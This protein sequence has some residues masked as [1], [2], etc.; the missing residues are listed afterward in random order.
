MFRV[1]FVGWVLF[2]GL[3]R[4]HSHPSVSWRPW[5]MLIYVLTSTWQHK[6]NQSVQVVPAS[7]CVTCT[8]ALLCFVGV[9][10][11][12]GE[13]PGDKSHHS[14]SGRAAQP[15]PERQQS[16]QPAHPN[17]QWAETCN[18]HPASFS[19]TTGR[20]QFFF[21]PTDIQCLCLL[22]S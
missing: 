14:D 5:Y 13:P 11:P 2:L 1:F 17:K 10:R 8:S 12:R 20:K 15:V 21:L 18:H 6:K 16:F 4:E 9:G 19:F 7:L 22:L 3:L